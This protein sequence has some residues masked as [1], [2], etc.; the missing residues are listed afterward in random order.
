MNTQTFTG[1]TFAEAMAKVKKE[2]GEGAVILKSEKKT[3]GGSFGL[4]G[5]E[6]VEVTAADSRELKVELESGTEFANELDV[7]TKDDHK[8]RASAGQT[9]EIALLRSEVSALRDQLSEIVKHFKYNNLPSMPET[10]SASL[11]KMT[12]AGIEKELATDLTAEALVQLGPEAL[13]SQEDISTFVIAKMGQIAPPA[14]NKILAR[15]GKPYK[16]ALV[17]APGA[18]KTSLLQKLATDPQGYGK[19]KIGLISL[20]THRLAAIE[21]LKTFARVSGLQIEIVYQPKDVA[22]AMNKLAGSQIILIDSPGCSPSED[23][24]LAE[25]TE[26]LGAIDPDETHLVLNST[27]RVAEQAAVARLFQ[28][29]GVTHLSMTRL[30]ESQ[31]P[32]SLVTISQQTKKPLAWL[33]NGQKFIGQ[34]ERYTHT[35]LRSKMF[36]SQ[37]A[38]SFVTLKS[39]A[40]HM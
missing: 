28:Q 40:S 19:L 15:G 25:L 34:I 12:S 4:S 20:D 33:S 32:G 27:T 35:W 2:L 39:V 7:Q 24:R 5:R 38:N 17:G 18:G 6:V 29:V 37:S 14:V 9:Y 31:Q 8:G 26:I 23:Q 11:S 21:Q 10:L 16:I 36:D 13:M 1:R 22:A 30:D 3:M